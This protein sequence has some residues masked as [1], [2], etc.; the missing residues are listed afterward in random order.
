MIYSPGQSLLKERTTMF[1]T[2]RH[3]ATGQATPWFRGPVLIR[4]AATPRKLI[5][6]VADGRA[7][8]ASKT[9]F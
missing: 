3:Q 6:A 1:G 2:D 9:G 4:D 8:A 7:A 5:P